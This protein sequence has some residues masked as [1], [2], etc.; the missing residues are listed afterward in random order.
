MK[1]NSFARRTLSVLLSAS[2]ALNSLTWSQRQ[3]EKPAPSPEPAPVLVTPAPTATPTSTPYPIEDQ[4]AY[5]FGEGASQGLESGIDEFGLFAQKDSIIREYLDNKDKIRYAQNEGVDT[6]HLF[7]HLAL[8]SEFRE[9]GDEHKAIRQK[10]GEELADKYVDEALRLSSLEPEIV[11]VS[12]RPLQLKSRVLYIPD[13]GK[14]ADVLTAID[15]GFSDD[16][17]VIALN[18]DKPDYAKG[19]AEYQA[20]TLHYGYS[21]IVN[22]LKPAEDWLA[23]NP[24]RVS[25]GLS[26][27]ETLDQL[28]QIVQEN[29]QVDITFNVHTKYDKDHNPIVF[30]LG[31]SEKDPMTDS[32]DYFETFAKKLAAASLKGDV[33]KLVLRLDACGGAKL[34]NLV[35]SSMEQQYRTGPTDKIPEVYVQVSSAGPY[36]G[37]NVTD[38]P[39]SSLATLLETGVQD[40][41]WD[42]YNV[43]DSIDYVGPAGRFEVPLFQ[44]GAA[45]LEVKTWRLSPD[46]KIAEVPIEEQIL[47]R[48]SRVESFSQSSP[49]ATRSSHSSETKGPSA[50]APFL[51]YNH[52]FQQK[53]S[54]TE[55]ETTYKQATSAYEVLLP[56]WQE[57]PSGDGNDSPKKRHVR[58]SP[59]SPSASELS[60]YDGDYDNESLVRLWK[61]YGASE[62]TESLTR[63]RALLAARRFDSGRELSP[64]DIKALKP[65]YSSLESLG[66][67]GK[68]TV[69]VQGRYDGKK[70][71]LPA[72]LLSRTEYSAV[73]N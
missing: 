14:Q 28:Y 34:A 72:D 43:V 67:E 23:Q 69:V 44:K 50:P 38:Y 11:S 8:P 42:K 56:S 59:E 13:I 45:D 71:F 41:E 60:V 40:L 17:T 68:E 9:L 49:T 1:G 37:M 39:F 35:L 7:T 16:L 33:D 70:Y 51:S 53:P 62:E 52:P 5:N 2:I 21:D 61:G 32:D 54:Q 30:H 12:G 31:S 57:T 66:V 26:T 64:E 25:T 65:V 6:T 18:N 47:L 3:P 15:G 63:R 73:T 4:F 48:P 29:Q 10:Y 20:A 27:K 46:G 55:K 58:I 19:N 22:I 24:D 36:L